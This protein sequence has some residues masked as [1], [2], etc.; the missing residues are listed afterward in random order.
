[1]HGQVAETLKYKITFIG[2]DATGKSSLIARFVYNTFDKAYLATMGIDFLSKT[3]YLENH[4]LRL[5]IWDCTGQYRFSSLIPSYIKDAAVVFIVFDVTQKKSYDSLSKWINMTR[6][7]RPDDSPI[8]LVAN[9]TDLTEKRVISTEE[10]TDFARRQNLSFIETSAKNSSNVEALFRQ[11]TDLLPIPATTTQ[12][13]PPLNFPPTQVSFEDLRAQIQKLTDDN[14]NNQQIKAIANIL[15]TGLYNPKP[16]EYFDRLFQ[17]DAEGTLKNESSLKYQIRQLAWTNP[18]LCNSVVNYL[19][20][21]VG[22]PLAYFLGVLEQNKKTH[23]HSCMFFAS[24]EKQQAISTCNQ[25]FDAVKASC[26]V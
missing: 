4:T 15:N 21:I 23:G 8:I 5:Q 25:V 26:R 6:A 7:G 18:S 14:P 22:L 10:I 12:K 19:L 11:C 13:E 17:A 2:D 20:T 1:M 9:K 16:K 3:M 24:G